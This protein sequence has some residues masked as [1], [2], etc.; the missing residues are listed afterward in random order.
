MN[1]TSAIHTSANPIETIR[2][3][4]QDHTI[5]KHKFEASDIAFPELTI[6]D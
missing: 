3:F 4:D 6:S 5:L 2:L 1:K